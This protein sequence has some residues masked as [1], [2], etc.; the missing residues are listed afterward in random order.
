MSLYGE[1]KMNATISPWATLAK[2]AELAGLRPPLQFYSRTYNVSDGQAT[3]IQLGIGNL[4]RI[5]VSGGGLRG[6]SQV[7]AGGHRSCSR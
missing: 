3:L 5:M 6:G 2:L 1:V 7:C 4:S